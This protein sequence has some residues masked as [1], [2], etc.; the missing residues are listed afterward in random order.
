MPTWQIA[1][2]AHKAALLKLFLSFCT[3]CFFFFPVLLCGLFVGF[4]PAASFSENTFKEVQKSQ[5]HLGSADGNKAISL[6]LAI[7]YKYI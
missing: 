5:G 6:F 4:Q 3:D 7:K 2:T 1:N